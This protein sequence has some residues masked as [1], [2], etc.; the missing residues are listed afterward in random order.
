MEHAE[1]L[2]KEMEEKIEQLS[3]KGS[4]F[5]S[6]TY[7]NDIQLDEFLYGMTKEQAIYC[8]I[9]SSKAA[10]RRGAFKIEES[11][12]VSKAIRVLGAF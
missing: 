11:E 4:L 8:L 12:A 3:P 10:Y 7:Y 6:I 5:E 1:E 9:E 2:K